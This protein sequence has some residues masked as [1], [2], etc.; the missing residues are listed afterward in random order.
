[1]PAPAE[2]VLCGAIMGVY[3]VRG[4]VR[5]RSD[6]KPALAIA[7]YRPWVLVTADG[8]REIEPLAVKEHGKGLVAQLTGVESRDQASQLIGIDIAVPRAAL[9]EAGEGEFYWHDLE[10]LAVVTTNDTALG[11]VE[12]LLETGAHDVMVVTGNGDDVLIPF[13]MPDVVREVDLVGRRIVVD[14]DWR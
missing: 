14:W 12:R 6:T 4:W 13:A 10:G 11:V 2:S 5:V 1:M 8:Q 7:S 3:G 9:P